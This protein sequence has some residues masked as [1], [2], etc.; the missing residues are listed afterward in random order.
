MGISERYA[1][2][3]GGSNATTSEVQTKYD[4]YDKSDDRPVFADGGPGTPVT[5]L[6]TPDRWQDYPVT[7]GSPPRTVG[8]RGRTFQAA[9]AIDDCDYKVANTPHASGMIVGLMD[10]SVRTLR[11]SISQEAYWGMVTPNAGEVISE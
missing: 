11:P 8:N 2:V 6:F 4:R 7:I 10:G 1:V 5:A 3:C 9:P